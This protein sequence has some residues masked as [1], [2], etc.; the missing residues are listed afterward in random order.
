MAIHS[1]AGQLAPHDS[2]V[3]LPELMTAYYLKK[4]DVAKNPEEGVSFGTSGHRG[5]ALLVSFNEDHILAISQ[6][7]AEYRKGQNIS[8]LCI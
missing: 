2:L 6:A 7:I 5:S 4:P 3:N 8:G 1:Q